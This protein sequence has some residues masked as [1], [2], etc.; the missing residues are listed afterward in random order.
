M[1][2]K[3]PEADIV[4]VNDGSTDD[5][6]S[7]AESQG[8][9]V[10][11]LPFN[12]GIGNTV[13]TGYR[14]A[15]E[16]GYSIA[17]QFDGDGQHNP[18][19]L[20]RIIDPVQTGDTDLCIGSRFLGEE[21]EGFR[22]NLRRRF[23]IWYISTLVYWLT[24]KRVQ[25]VTSGFRAM[26]TVVIRTFCDHYPSDY[27]EPEAIILLVNEGLRI[28]EVPVTMFERKEGRS[29]IDSL[30]SIYYMVKVPMSILISYFRR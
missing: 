9:T 19:D 17:V 7:R 4:V 13:Q 5:T 1:R 25:D 12:T 27:P 16:G 29:S 24:G 28:K 3:V 14:Y 18:A 26:N 21:G 20:K 11:H 6:G 15:L 2:E 8:V 30:Q 10:L 23:G 22:P